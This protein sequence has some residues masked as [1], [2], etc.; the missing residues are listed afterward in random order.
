MLVK[1]G[2]KVPLDGAVVGGSSAVDEAALTGESRPVPK[3]V[4]ASVY[5]G[6]VNQAGLHSLPGVR[7]VTWTTL[8][9]VIN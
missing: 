7:F 2:E 3:G 4:G 8:L 9:D 6:T 1:P 5:G